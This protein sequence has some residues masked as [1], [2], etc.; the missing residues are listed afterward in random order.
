MME[1]AMEMDLKRERVRQIRDK[2]LRK[3]K[4]LKA[5]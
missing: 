4:K 1:A 3:L 2:A 5:Q